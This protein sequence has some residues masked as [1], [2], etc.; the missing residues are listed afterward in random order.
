MN[1]FYFFGKWCIV[2][3][4]VVLLSCHSSRQA[5]K[6]MEKGKYEQAQAKL[7]KSLTKD[8]LNP[9]AHYVYSLLFVDTAYQH[10]QVD[11][12]YFHILEAISDYQTADVKTQQKLAKKIGMDSASL[13]AQKLT[14]DSLAFAEASAIHTVT[15]YQR[16]ID[17]HTSSAPQYEEAIRQR[18]QLAFNAAKQKDT[19]Q[20]YKTFMDI[21]PDAEQYELAKERYNTLAFREK[22]KGGSLESYLNFLKTFPNSPYRPNAEE[23]IMK[24][25]VADNRLEHYAIFARQYPESPYAKWSVDILYHLYKGKHDARNFL[26]DF[27]QLPYADSLQKII[28][29]EKKLLTPVLENERYGFMD[30]QGNMVIPY[31]YPLILAKYLCEG[32]L[33]DFINVANTKGNK[34]QH[35]LLTKNGK[36]VTTISND[37]IPNTFPGPFTSDFITDIGMGWLLIQEH[38]GQYV[39]RHKAGYRM[40][41]EPYELLDTLEFIPSPAALRQQ[42]PFQFIKFQTNGL[43]GLMTFTGKTLLE[44]AY[45]DIEEYDHFIVVEKDGKLAVTNRDALIQKANNVPLTLSFLY[46]DV[47]LID[48]HYLIAYTDEYETALNEQLQTEVP[49]GKY[50]IVRRISHRHQWL[51]KKETTRQFIRNDSLISVKQPAYF[52]YDSQTK[53]LPHEYKKA[54][55]NEKWLAL[56]K[57]K[58]FEFFDF[59]S[60]TPSTLYDSV[61]ILSENLVLLFQQDSI[62][63][64]FSN[65]NK[66]NFARFNDKEELQFRLLKSMSESNL[67]LQKEY[68]LILK[69][70]KKQVI[71]QQG[72][73]L[74]ASS[75]DEITAYPHDL[76]VIE[77][78][79]KK[80]LVDSTGNNLILTKYQSIGNYKDGILAIFD[81]QKFGF[82]YQ[83]TQTFV[84]PE[85]EAMVQ[86]YGAPSRK[87]SINTDLFIARK[88]GK[89][90]IINQENKAI[91]PFAFE[92]IQIWNDT[93]ALVKTG[94]E[95]QLYWLT[96][97]ADT[98]EENRILL[99]GV[100]DFEELVSGKE[101][102][103]K[104]Y[105]NN[106]YGI[107]SNLRGEIISPAYD[108]I[109]L[110]GNEADHIFFTEKYVA[111]AELYIILYFDASG[112][113]L[114][115][116]ALTA[117]QYD[118]IYCDGA[119]L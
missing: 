112:K 66:L 59:T 88:K 82:Y 102:V 16:F 72:N 52:L 42:V 25:S 93:T 60:N 78:N 36:V 38:P 75:M 92:Q 95:W 108:E 41:P 94:E 111:E 96:A 44:A 73:S 83:G 116:Q 26:K 23:Q 31:Q 35:S 20:A 57:G 53:E 32:I 40:M 101:K 69:P 110:L 49:L 5:L 47:A 80:G 13:I 105:K 74:F 119:Y 109:I 77:K 30:S 55:Y 34:L 76:F 70:D 107:I 99:E 24:I 7:D 9:A 37:E 81:N 115:R 90:G 2:S 113:M 18:N 61:K 8:S 68:L 1:K 85:Y 6:L 14:T 71:D 62:T 43:W 67:A 29:A 84:K 28:E 65:Q 114:K 104:I 97:P 64:H 4:A 50:N 17:E 87:D 89:Y 19:Y 33:N 22:T 98:P 11:S 45:D 15:A 63:A 39:V 56:Q 3:L 27:P 103:L 106:A 48:N 21:Y 86:L 12:A 10:Y 79:G 100:K 117:E 51:L 54:F 91:T 118:K 58:G 46:E